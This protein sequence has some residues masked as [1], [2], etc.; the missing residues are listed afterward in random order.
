[1]HRRSSGQVDRW[2]QKFGQGGLEDDSA[3]G[4]PGD[5]KCGENVVDGNCFDAVVVSLAGFVFIAGAAG[6]IGLD[7]NYRLLRTYAILRIDTGKDCHGRSAQG[8]SQV[9]DRRIHGYYDTSSAEQ[10]EELGYL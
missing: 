8:S 9:Q 2:W 1:M 6:Q 4:I 5:G 10:A 7:G 3:A